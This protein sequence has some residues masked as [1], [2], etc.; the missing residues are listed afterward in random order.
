MQSTT[1]GLFTS[2]WLLA[3]QAP[4]ATQTMTIGSAAP[5]LSIAHWMKGS[6]VTTFAPGQVY[7]LEF[8]AT[9]CAPCVANMEHLSK[10]QETY[11]DRGVHVIGL[12]DEPLQTT[13]HFLCHACDKQGTRQDERV[14]YAL[15][16]D[17]DRSVHEGYFEAAG[18]RGIP[19]CF[20]IGKTGCIEWIGHPKD[21]DAVIEAVVTDTWDRA[22]H[23][24]KVEARQEATK[25]FREAR[26]QLA[27]AMKDQRWDDALLA[28]HVLE[29]EP[30]EG[31]LSVPAIA[32]ILLS[33]KKD[34][35]AGMAYVRR[36]TKQHWNDDS[37]LLYQMAWLLSGRDDFPIAKDK[38]D[39]DL[40]LSYAE[41]AVE[42]DAYD[43]YCTM[44]ASIRAQR[45]EFEAACAAQQRAIDVLESKR[46][47]ILM[48]EMERFE[49]ELASMR[50]TL[51]KYRANG[52]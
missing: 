3:L 23:L 46:P 31:D 4:L 24:A 41:R 8:W 32:G 18:L 48:T 39:L 9:W 34:H 26:R 28:L 30:D 36:V 33:R 19:A 25:E 22:A 13:V 11:G 50:Q 38:L 17:P 43:Y 12:S 2:F 27:A 40:A 47:K 14:R 7:V 49:A 6:E 52:K 10:L 29:H 15:A 1:H 16:T 21:L 20:V 45:G 37:W 42:L 5:P 51:E 35:E 44:L